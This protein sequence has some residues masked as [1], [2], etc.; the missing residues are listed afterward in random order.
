MTDC[1]KNSLTQKQIKDCWLD[2]C[3]F[4]HTSWCWCLL[5]DLISVWC[6]YSSD[7]SGFPQ[8]YSWCGPTETVIRLVLS[9]LVGV[10]TVIILVYDIRSRRAEQD[11]AHIPASGT[12]FIMSWFRKYLWDLLKF[13][14]LYVHLFQVLKPKAENWTLKVFQVCF[15]FL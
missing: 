15:L 1:Y 14:D 13:I 3:L 8:V 12:G 9:A 7:L 10:A 11:Q 6:V 2:F 4:R 5:T